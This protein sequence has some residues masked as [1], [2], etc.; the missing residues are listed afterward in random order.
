MVEIQLS[1][2]NHLGCL[3][4]NLVRYLIQNP[5][6]VVFKIRNLIEEL[7]RLAGVEIFSVIWLKMI[8]PL[9]SFLVVDLVGEE[10]VYF[11]NVAKC[12]GFFT[13][14]DYD[15]WER[16][17]GASKEFIPAILDSPNT[18]T[19]IQKVLTVGTGRFYKDDIQLVYER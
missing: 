18:I 10:R 2:S 12:C 16:S 8:D 4:S 17:M 9:N 3:S 14:L 5:P 19:M 6:D 1:L 7:E 13:T 11:Y 15:F